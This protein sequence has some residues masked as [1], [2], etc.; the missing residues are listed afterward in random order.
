M[1]SK[2]EIMAGRAYVELFVKNSLFMKGLASAKKS[3]QDFGSS[4]LKAGGLLMAAGSGIIAPLALMVNQFAAAGSVLYDM[5]Q[6]T[7][8]SASSLAELGYA[9]EQSGGSIEDVETSIRKMQ[10]ALAAAEKTGSSSKSG[11]K[12]MF[13]AMISE[14][15]DS[16]AVATLTKLGLSLETLKGLTVDEKFMKVAEGLAAIKDPGARATA[17][18]EIFGKTGTKI[19]PML[20]G[21]IEALRAMR[22]EARD[23]GAPTDQEAKLADQLGDAFGR[24]KTIAFN[25]AFSI[26]GALAPMVLEAAATIQK[27]AAAAQKWIRENGE[28]VRTV[29]KLAVQVFLAG[30]AITAI[31]AAIWGLGAA[32]GFAATLASGLGVVLGVALSPVV[33]WTA[34]IGL[35]LYKTKA[36]G[37][38]FTWLGNTLAPVGARAREVF[39]AMQADFDTA[40]KGIQDAI[41]AGDFGLALE[42]AWAGMR[43]IWQ[44]ATI[45]VNKMWLEAKEY[46]LSIWSE[47]QHG[48]GII[49][50]DAIAVMKKAWTE[51]VSF[52]KKLWDGVGAAIT[53][54]FDEIYRVGAKTK[55]AFTAKP[56]M[57]NDEFHRYTRGQMSPE[58]KAEIEERIR[59][60]K[61]M[62]KQQFSDIDDTV[63]NAKKKTADTLSADLAEAEKTRQQ[64]LL[65]I[66]KERLETQQALTEDMARNKTARD[67]DYAA[68]V[69]AK[70]AELEAARAALDAAAGKAAEAKRL[71][72]GPERGDLPGLELPDI[73]AG[74]QSRAATTFSAAALVALGQGGGPQDRLLV[75]AKEQRKIQAK[76]LAEAEKMRRKLDVLDMAARA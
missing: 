3:V 41:A 69:A 65:K 44:Q 56:I 68:A 12:G 46:F 58:E 36:L 10:K 21:G 11:K 67:A 40:W 7:G 2:S 45:D 22:Q 30:A 48:L 43:V 49:F 31:G 33:L 57:T 76:F 64:D 37:G 5:S 9:A 17:A 13:G 54:T 24:L 27:L 60:N 20:D 15:K 28:L 53:D 29:A 55:A 71:G 39:G 4:F 66:E 25:T 73:G 70:Q 26:G 59:K 34:A 51:A 1:S 19:L 42:V 23:L 14:D 50:I 8:A 16:D 47:A 63:N 6:R 18:M 74:S 61:E 38:L 32:F 72:A 52:M 75:E 62:L 35:L